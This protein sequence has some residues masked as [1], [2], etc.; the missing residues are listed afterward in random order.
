MKKDWPRVRLGEVLRPVARPEVPKPGAVYRQIGVKLWGVGAYEREQLDGGATKYVTLFRAEA[1]DVIVNKIWAR[2][3]SVAVVSSALA[4]CYGSGE[5]PM[6][7][8]NREKLDPAWMHWLTKTPAFWAQC[9]EKSQGTSGQNRIRP[10]RFLEIDIPLPPVPEQRRMVARIE[11]LVSQ[12]Q[13]ARSLRQKAVEEADAMMLS[14]T[15]AVFDSLL[16]SPTAPLSVLGVGGENP[17][18][19]GPFGAQLHASDFVE[20]G[21]PVLNV[22]NVRPEGL[23]FDRLDHIHPDKAAELGRYSLKPDDLLFARSGA[24]LGKVC[25]V[26]KEC[27]GWLMTGHLFRLRFD[28]SRVFH[29]FAFAG[30]RGARSMHEQI[31]RQVRGATRPGYNT[32]LLGNVQIPLPAL[33][34]QRRIVAELDGLQAEV[35]AVKHL[36][37]ETAVELDALLPTILDRAFNGEL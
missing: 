25:I 19:T 24:T 11:E 9:D 31:F 22:G 10:E 1:G 2:S 37:T 33:P 8:S 4:G 15:S 32:T 16:G 14:K 7:S 34:E 3:G 18:Q 6:F 21:V 5:F 26:P 23:R 29:R 20:N 12:I 35:E 28:Q 30:L 17:V 36:Q 27:D 13:E